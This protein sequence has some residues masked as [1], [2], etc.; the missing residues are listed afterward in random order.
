MNSCTGASDGPTAALTDRQVM[1][2]EENDLPDDNFGAMNFS[3]LTT[4][5]TWTACSMATWSRNS[6]S[7]FERS[8]PGRPRLH[9]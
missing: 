3:S 9:W 1:A 5:S 6:T 4:S 2:T 7:V 8:Y